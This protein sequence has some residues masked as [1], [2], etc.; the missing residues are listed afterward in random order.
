MKLKRIG[1]EVQI[2]MRRGWAQA[3]PRALYLLQQEL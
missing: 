3:H 1:M 2:Q